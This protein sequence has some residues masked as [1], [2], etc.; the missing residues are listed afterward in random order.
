VPDPEVGPT[1]EE[2]PVVTVA[3]G[4]PPLVRVVFA[5]LHKSI[6]PPR[7]RQKIP[8]EINAISAV[9]RQYSA[10]SCARSLRKKR[11]NPVIENETRLND[12][13]PVRSKPCCLSI[14]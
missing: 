13:R 7:I 4:E 10:R 9:S 11:A 3:E 2:V 12:S 8:S 14:W 6:T 5:V 1:P